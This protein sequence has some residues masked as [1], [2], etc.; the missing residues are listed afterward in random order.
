MLRT[1][2]FKA[3]LYDRAQTNDMPLDL[4]QSDS[5][6]QRPKRTRSLTTTTS[7]ATV[8]FFYHCP[9]CSFRTRRLFR[10]LRRQPNPN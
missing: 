1:V 5:Q 8:P 7:V 9:R 6:V 3:I 10:R 4:S 2:N